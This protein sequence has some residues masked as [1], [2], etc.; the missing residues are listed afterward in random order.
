MKGDR[1]LIEEQHT[2]AG[3]HITNLLLPQVP[4]DQ[5][6]FVLTIAG[7]SGSGKSEIASVLSQCLSD[8]HIPNVIFQQDDYFVLPPKTN[9]AMRQR[10]IHQVGPSEVRLDLLDL[11]LHQF[12]HGAAE[13]QKPLVIFDE[14]EITQETVSVKDVRLIIVEGTYTT[15]LRNA[16][17]RVFIDRTYFDTRQVRKRRSREQQNELLEKI[18]AI[19]HDVISSHKGRADIVVTQDYEV[20]QR[21]DHSTT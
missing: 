6:R 18:L 1:L 14:D 12:L 16:H 3:K 7:E 11:N 13:I 21:N 19:E 17:Q 9:A 15:I 8:A 5:E 10:N 20:R 4:R 2:K